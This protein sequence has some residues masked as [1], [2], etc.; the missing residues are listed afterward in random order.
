MLD[1]VLEIFGIVP[2]FDLNIM[3]QN[4]DLA[5][6]TTAALNGLV[7][8]ISRA[9]PDL[10]LVH[11]DT[12]TTMAASLAAYYTRTKLGHVE[13]GLRTY[14]KFAPYPEEA[15]R[16]IVAALADLNFAPTLAAKANLLAENVSANSIFVTGNTAI[17][18][19]DSLVSQNYCFKEA[20]LN[21]IDFAAK[22][23]ITM[24][25]HRRENYGQP[26]E[27]IFKAVARLAADFDDVEIVYPVHLAPAVS[28]IA[29]K[30]LGNNNKIHLIAPTDVVDLLN[31]IH[32]SYMV[33][34]D[35]GGI[36][37]EAPHLDKPVLVLREV[38][39]RPEGLKTGCLELAGTSESGVYDAATRLLN[40][41]TKYDSMA[42][43]KNPFGD[44]AASRRI[45]QAILYHFGLTEMRPA[46]DFV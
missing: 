5:H 17:D 13:A 28:D 44:G 16:K 23:V 19:I 29:H 37:E 15:N 45:H 39:E 35:S 9:K 42:R 24:T 12:T 21:N 14:N 2:D 4:Q 46:E 11:G 30:I 43:A 22:R 34:T 6:I 18:A 40:D 3:V 10:I 25:A 33:M 7:D 41:T 32:R 8:V 1:Q 31:L 36:Q 27:N 38:T 20:R 26:F